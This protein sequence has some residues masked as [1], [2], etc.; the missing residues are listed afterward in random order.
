MISSGRFFP[1]KTRHSFDL[2]LVGHS[3]IGR[4]VMVCSRKLFSNDWLQELEKEN[5][6]NCTFAHDPQKVYEF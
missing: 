4:Q 6:E 2:G 5:I 3:A 1:S